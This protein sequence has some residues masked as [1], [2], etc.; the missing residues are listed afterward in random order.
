MRL[1]V[2]LLAAGMAIAQTR[3]SSPV[4]AL[5]R[6]NLL[7]GGEI[8]VQNTSRAT[9]VDI[10]ATAIA[11]MPS[12]AKSVLGIGT[13]T[14]HDATGATKISISNGGTSAGGIATTLDTSSNPVNRLDENG[15]QVKF[16]TT[17][18][19]TGSA[20]YV[21]AGAGVVNVKDSSGNVKV[22]LSSGGAGFGLLK[23]LDASGNIGITIDGSGATP[24]ADNTYA[25]GTPAARWS[26]IDT[27]SI[28]LR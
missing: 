4:T 18:K 7:T 11:V 14:E 1:F 19:F 16:L 12:N 2:A 8:I 13:F 28:H 27:A 17:Q 20:S 21:E 6:P 23:N 15:A 25:L 10:F 3:L 5:P 24:G 9:S 22:L 26:D